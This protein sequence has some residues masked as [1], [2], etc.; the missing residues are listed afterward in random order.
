MAEVAKDPNR[1]WTAAEIVAKS[2]DQ[3]RVGTLGGPAKYSGLNYYVLGMVIE[4]VTGRPL[5]TALREDLLAPAGLDRIWMQ[6]GEKPQPPLAFPVDDPVAKVVDPQGGYLPSRG[7][8]STGLGGAGIAADAPSLARW[9]YLLYGGHVIDA[10]LVKIMETPDPTGEF[11]YGFGTMITDD[12]GTVIVGHAGNFIQYTSIM[13][14][15][16]DAATSVVV[17]VPQTGGPE[18]QARGDLAFELYSTLQSATG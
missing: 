12:N 18:N 3:P 1:E 8:A 17:L 16:P 7:A 13:L 6:T 4:K 15:W 2:V 5:A 10:D 14:V 9:G 11:T